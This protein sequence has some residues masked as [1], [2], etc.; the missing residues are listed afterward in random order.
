MSSNIHFDF[1]GLNELSKKM[2]AIS[3]THSYKISE[4]LTDNFIR[5]NSKF[6]TLDEFMKTCGINNAEEFKA[7]PESEMDKF[8]GVAFL[9]VLIFLLLLLYQVLILLLA[10]FITYLLSILVLYALSVIVK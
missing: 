6:S 10:F 3:G 5:E 2:N 1:S 7:F 4:V 8:L 9:F